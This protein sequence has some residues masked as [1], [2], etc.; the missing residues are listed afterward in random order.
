MWVN[1]FWHTNAA[2]LVELRVLLPY[3]SIY[4]FFLLKVGNI[5]QPRHQRR[6]LWVVSFTQWYFTGWSLDIQMYP[7]YPHFWAFRSSQ[8]SNRCS[9]C[10]LFMFVPKSKSISLLYRIPLVNFSYFYQ[11]KS[12]EIDFFAHY[13][14]LTHKYC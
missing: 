9:I 6:L 2:I 11:N 5:T 10:P 1:T 12:T 8:D 7:K 4:P 14:I 3:S 13:N